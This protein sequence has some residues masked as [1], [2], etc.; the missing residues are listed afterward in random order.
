MNKFFQKKT[1]A[2]KLEKVFS[3]KKLKP[4]NQKN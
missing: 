1:L 3:K 2:G 4:E